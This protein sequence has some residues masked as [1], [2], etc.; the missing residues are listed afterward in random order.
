MTA[1]TATAPA[2]RCRTCDAPIIW[3]T[4]EST[5]KAMPVDAEPSPA[6][7]VQLIPREGRTPLARVIPARDRFAKTLHTSHFATCPQASQH[8]KR[9]RGQA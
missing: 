5:L 8:R 9:G 1:A 6:G 2:D 3:A 7:S 4:S